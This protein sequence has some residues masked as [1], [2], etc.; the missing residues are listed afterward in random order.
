GIAQLLRR[1]QELAIDV[2]DLHSS[3][4]SLEEIFVNLVRERA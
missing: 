4:S 2:K 1:L 3:E